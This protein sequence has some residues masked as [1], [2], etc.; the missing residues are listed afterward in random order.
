MKERFERRPEPPSE[1][2]KG[3]TKKTSR[4]DFLKSIGKVALAV[5]SA[6]YGVDRLVESA[7]EHNKKEK[8]NKEH[9][10]IGEGTILEKREDPISFPDSLLRFQVHVKF[11]D[12]DGWANLTKGEFNSC[13]VGG[14]IPVVYDDRNKNILK[15]KTEL[16]GYEPFVGEKRKD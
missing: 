5:G 15:L 7:Q 1:D 13:D 14:K 10:Q 11:E 6:A 3:D 4:R 8:E 2:E 16:Y 12:K 9:E